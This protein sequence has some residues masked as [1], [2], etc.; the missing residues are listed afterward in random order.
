MPKTEFFLASIQ[1]NPE[2]VGEYIAEAKSMGVDISAPDINVSDVDI[3]ISGTNIVFGFFNVKNVGKAAAQYLVKLR[4][5]WGPFASRD[6]LDGI[7]EDEIIFWE[8]SGSK[9]R[10]PKQKLG[11][12][13]VDALDNAGCFDKLTECP[14]LL[15]RSKL[16]KELLGI[17][18]VDVYSPLL[19]THAQM[20]QGLKPISEFSGEGDTYGI[21]SEVDIRKTRADSKPG[22]ANKTYAVLTMEWQMQTA[23]VTTFEYREDMVPGSFWLLQ[24]K[25]NDRGMTAKSSRCLQ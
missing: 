8:H 24:I 1:T 10:S 5:K 18:F 19:K 2:Q 12:G 15:L 14:D 4:D 11:K 16:Q 9:G 17:S 22:F 3:S 23:K 13:A 20:L 7:L 25:S 21:I 6:H